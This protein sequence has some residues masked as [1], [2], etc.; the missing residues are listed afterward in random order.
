MSA[1]VKDLSAASDALCSGNLDFVFSLDKAGVPRWARTTPSDTPPDF[2][3]WKLHNY[4]SLNLP[5]ASK[6]IHTILNHT[7]LKQE[8]FVSPS[9]DA[10]NRTVAIKNEYGT[11]HTVTNITMGDTVLVG[12]W[13][14]YLGR[15]HMEDGNVPNG[16]GKIIDVGI[17]DVDDGMPFRR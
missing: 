10:V 4:E 12:E 15:G 16:T 6:V 7:N 11:N 5:A 14:G 1:Q 8:V 2:R 17:I 13:E 3:E 9:D